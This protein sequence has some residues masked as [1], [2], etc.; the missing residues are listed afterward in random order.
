MHIMAGKT[1]TPLST[2]PLTCHADAQDTM[3]RSLLRRPA[4]LR[5]QAVTM[6]LAIAAAAVCSAT[7]RIAQRRDPALMPG[8]AAY[9]CGWPAGMAAYAAWPAAAPLGTKLIYFVSSF[10]PLVYHTQI[11]HWGNAAAMHVVCATVVATAA[12]LLHLR[13]Q[14]RAVAV[15]VGWIAAIAA[16]PLVIAMCASP[17]SGVACSDYTRPSS[18]FCPACTYAQVSMQVCSIR[19]W[20]SPVLMHTKLSTSH[21]SFPC[22]A[23]AAAAASR[24]VP[25]AV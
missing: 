9:D 6:H 8:A 12:R 5:S 13:H 19:L 1:P 15:A 7:W 2:H 25:K 18:A 14:G 24:F 3:L 17:G 22:N 20:A 4:R 21:C 10:I 23:T 16:Y 11:C